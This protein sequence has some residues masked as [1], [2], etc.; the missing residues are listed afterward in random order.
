MSWSRTSGHVNVGKDDVRR[1]GIQP[2]DRRL[3]VTDGEDAHV[4]S[5]KCQLDHSLDRDA[6]IGQEKVVRQ[7]TDYRP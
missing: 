2:I 4:F 6:V 5:D 1:I 7:L 3:A